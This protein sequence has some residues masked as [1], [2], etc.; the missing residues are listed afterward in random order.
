M[1]NKLLLTIALLCNTMLVEAQA[2]TVYY[3][4]A[5]HSKAMIDA[6]VTAFDTDEEARRYL[7]EHQ[8]VTQLFSAYDKQAYTEALYY[9]H[10]LENSHPDAVLALSDSLQAYWDS[11]YLQS[12][13][14][15]SAA[16]YGKLKFLATLGMIG[17]GL[18]LWK[19][20]LSWSATLKGL[21]FL[22][23][24]T[25]SV[26][27]YYAVEFFRQ[28]LPDVPLEPQQVLSFASG[29]RY[30]SYA[31]KRND[32]LYRLFGVGIGLGA[33]EFIFQALGRNFFRN[34]TQRNAASKEKPSPAATPSSNKKN[35]GGAAVSDEISVVPEA[36]EDS[37]KAANSQ[38]RR[39]ASESESLFK[40]R[41]TLSYFARAAGA[42]LGIYLLQK[43]THLMLREV[44]VRKVEHQLTQVLAEFQA[45]LRNG[46]QQALIGSAKALVEA[47]LQLVTLYELPQLQ[48]MAEFE[49]EFSQHAGQLTNATDEEL[50]TSL[51]EMTLKLSKSLAAKLSRAMAQKNY[52]YDRVPLLQAL[53]QASYTQLRDSPDKRIAAIVQEFEQQQDQA[54][55][56]NTDAD[57]AQDLDKKF[58]AWVQ[59]AISDR[60]A[61]AQQALTEGKLQR[62]IELLFQVAAIFKASAVVSEDFAF[63]Q[64][65]H[66]RLLAKFQNMLLMYRNFDQIIEHN[67]VWKIKF[68]ATELN[69]V[70]DL[71]LAYHQA[72][73][74]APVQMQQQGRKVL[75]STRGFARFL[76]E[77][78]AALPTKDYN[79]LLL[80]VLHIYREQ[81]QH[82]GALV[83]L[84]QD[85]E[86]KAELHDSYYD[87][88]WLTTIEG[89]LIG[90]GLLMLARMTAKF[91]HVL[92]ADV[93]QPR[94]RWIAKLLGTDE[95]LIHPK[96]GLRRFGTRKHWTQLGKVALA[97]ATAGYAY[98]FVNKLRTHKLPPKAALLDVQ[99]G[100][101]FD[102]AQRSCILWHEVKQRVKGKDELQGYAA[103]QIQREREALQALAVRLQQLSGQAQHLHTSAPSLRGNHLVALPQVYEV[104]IQQ[105]V[106]TPVGQG[107]TVVSLTPLTQDLERTAGRLRQWKQ[108]LDVIEYS[109]LQQGS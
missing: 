29:A 98:Y 65:F 63:L 70:L 79:Q 88:V 8:I 87:S 73:S 6:F 45:D 84:V 39:L 61:V 103:E 51:Q 52:R 91:A 66:Q 50:R 78:I 89:S 56:L 28:P 36:A 34:T 13:L 26:G 49:K 19:N 35:T 85:V 4:D 81:P 83:T 64:H 68:S 14:V 74:S 109:R 97:G 53:T 96:K 46:E 27:A 40:P 55:L 17:G 108:T 93:E 104:G 58:N 30:F 75:T 3:R 101:V 22:L 59:L 80:R 42:I 2:N 15:G 20:P 67:A 23:P 10:S 86:E 9:L 76:A 41:L 21:N 72:D 54:V 106:P 7:L 31:Q 47:T 60:Y 5:T 12:Y 48:V 95:P 105:C 69:A 77:Y 92:G 102:L 62:N 1:M 33:G 16:E 37:G 25:G 94:W 99:K 90:A 32:Y 24:L 38:T 18:S 43:G 100:L 71:Y 44:E 107:Q 82:R 57:T 11:H